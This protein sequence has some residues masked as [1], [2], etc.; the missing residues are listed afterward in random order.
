M[1][2]AYVIVIDGLGVGAQEDAHQYGDEE[3]N[4]LGHVC[5]DTGVK[6]PNLQKMGIG[7]IIP[8]ESVAPISEPLSAWGKLREVSAGKDS[9][10]GHWEIAGVQL[11]RPFPTY[12]EGFAL[13][14]INDFCEGIGVKK[15]LCNKPYSG[16]DVI[17]DYGEEHLETGYPIVYTSADSVFQ[18]ACHTDVVSVEK[19]YEWCE[20]ARNE[21]MTGEH[22][23][24]RVIARPFEGEPGN[25]ERISD[26]RHDYSSTPPAH[27]LVQVLYDEGFKTYSIGKVADL[28][29]GQGFTQYR[30]TKSNAE[31]ISQL[32]SLMSAGLDNSF[33]FVNLIDTDQLFGHRL[34]PEGY[35]G[36]LEEFD[37]AIP[38]LVSK[39][40]EDD[41]LII[42]GDHG[43]DPCS[44]S[45]DHSR[46]FVPL[47]VFPK[48]TAVQENLGTGETFSNIASSVAKFFGLKASF[49]GQSFVE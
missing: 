31:G 6:L 32:L 48:A 29:A 14:V 17:R 30:P 41:L 28:F 46:E 5:R 19:L 7:N 13:E 20:F 22:E 12:P 38:A 4:T 39:I 10:T 21:V 36:S 25:F 1:G 15:A 40:R 34:D 23:V 33:V 44:D 37:R 2:N 11:E 42:T 16:T 45:T 43:N 35:A 18:V 8:L 3:M 24:G 9:T 27:N 26:K 47:L 49:P